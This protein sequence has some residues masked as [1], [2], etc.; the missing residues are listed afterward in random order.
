MQRI[1]DGLAVPKQQMDTFTGKTTFG[2][3]ARIGEVDC[4]LTYIPKSKN[5]VL[6]PVIQTPTGFM[7]NA[8]VKALSG[9]LV[10]LKVY[11]PAYEKAADMNN[12]A[13]A[14]NGSGG[15]ASHGKHVLSYT[16]IGCPQATVANQALE[17]IRVN[18]TV[19]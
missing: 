9:K 17:V 18:Y 13:A 2:P 8:E 15:A 11:L 3:G 10:T 19:A 16:Y 5:H 4:D 6:V 14:C 1:S 12:A 7:L